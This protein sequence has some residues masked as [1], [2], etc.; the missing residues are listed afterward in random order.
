VPLPPPLSTESVSK[1]T[2]RQVVLRNEQT[3][4][5]ESEHLERNAGTGI[6]MMSN[7]GPLDSQGMMSI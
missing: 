3:Q 1:R 2:T 7:H 4:S 5:K 6:S